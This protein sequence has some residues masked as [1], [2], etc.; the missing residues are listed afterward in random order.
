MTGHSVSV[1]EKFAENLELLGEN[2]NGKCKNLSVASWIKCPD[3]NHSYTTKIRFYILHGA[4]TW[5]ADPDE[6]CSKLH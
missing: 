5:S 6:L 4:H 2:D 1:F 3:P